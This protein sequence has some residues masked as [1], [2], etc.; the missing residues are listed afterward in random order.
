MPEGFFAKSELLVSKAPPSRV[1]KCG[2]CG[3]YKVCQSPK[4]RPTGK[5]KRQILIIGEAP[6]Q[7]EDKKGRHFVGKSGQFLESTLRRL[8]VDMRRDCWLTNA[9]ICRPPGNE[10][11]DPNKISYCHPNLV[12]TLEEYQPDVII[13]VGDAAV[14]SLIGGL[15]KEDP[16][17]ISKWAGFRI[18]CQKLNAWIC[19]TFSPSQVLRE[20]KKQ[21]IVNLFF[22]K[23]LRNAIEL[24][25][26][27]KPFPSGPID[28]KSQVKVVYDH[29]KAARLIDEMVERGGLT[30]FDY[31]GT[32]LKPETRGWVLYT[33]SIC[34]RGK[35]TIAYPWEGDAIEATRRY[36]RAKNCYKI[37]ANIKL[38]DRWT[39]RYFGV[40][41]RGWVW[42]C[43]LGAHINDHRP[44]ITGVKFQS[45]V[46]LGVED[47]AEH[48]TP[49]LKAKKGTTVNQIMEE[50][51]LSQLLKYNGLDSLYEYHIG[52]RQ[53][54]EMGYDWKR[55]V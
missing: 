47:Y 26:E 19:P 45:F 29:K 30:A 12:K 42:D 2:A 43:N 49:L 22:E 46:Q 20:E 3:L 24:A 7:E 41:C 16:G 39:R 40:P 55:Y 32:T 33:A 1:P 18:P 21:P 13:P 11:P 9:I 27:G 14:R 50:V 52:L 4:M 54:K 17:G 25:D 38:E 37:G 34:W 31:E 36:L 6:G 28:Y 8:G 5:G 10:T 44:D 48:I 23:H 53:M 15:W 51:E 35:L